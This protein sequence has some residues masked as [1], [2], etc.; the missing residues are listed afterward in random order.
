MSILLLILKII[1]II[2]LSIL[3]LFLLI[4]LLVLFVPIRYKLIVKKPEDGDLNASV[5]ITW[6][7]HFINLVVKYTDDLYFILRIM[8]IPIIKS[9]NLK[10]KKKINTVKSEKTEE[11][12]TR[13]EITEVKPYPNTTDEKAAEVKSEPIDT[14]EEYSDEVEAII[15]EP[16][17]KE[18]KESL[19][20]KIVIIIQKVIDFLFNIKDKIYGIYNKCV[21]IYENIEYYVDAINDERNKQ[22]ISLCFAKLKDIINNIKPSKIH[23]II[24]YGSDDPYN[25]GQI[26]TIYGIL[27]PIIHD[28]IQ[29]VPEY[30]YDVVDIDLLIKG[31]I[32]GVVLIW[33]LIKIYFNKDFKRMLKI[34]NRE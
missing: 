10:K 8:I 18:A 25:M 27:Y 23:G 14:S 29:I 3:G 22:V 21:D 7:L 19:F 34:F 33:A 17:E 15:N 2:L 28:K 32:T 24:K 31:R 16:D 6:L 4:I 13:A 12:N 20:D 9:D 11:N 1:G 26:M 30:D 5:K